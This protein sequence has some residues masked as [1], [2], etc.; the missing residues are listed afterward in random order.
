M[1]LEVD[2]IPVDIFNARLTE[3]L[4]T[5]SIDITSISVNVLYMLLSR[6]QAP[7]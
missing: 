7:A 5:T 4:A 6:V 2:I 3:L 1:L